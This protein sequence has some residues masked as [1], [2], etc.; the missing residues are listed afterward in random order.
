MQTMLKSLDFAL[1]MKAVDTE[2]STLVSD[3]QVISKYDYF[4]Q[5][6]K[7]IGTG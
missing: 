5:Q 6:A 7:P 2:G 3:C 4:L 1:K